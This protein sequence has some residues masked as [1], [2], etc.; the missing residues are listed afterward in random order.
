MREKQS[1]VIL[2]S[3]SLKTGTY[4]IQRINGAHITM[5]RYVEK[6]LEPWVE[7]CREE[8]DLSPTQRALTILDVYKAHQTSDVIDVL[9]EAGFELVFVP[10]N[11]TSE[12]EPLQL[13]VN[14]CFKVELKERFTVWYAE[15][16]QSAMRLHPDDV[17]VAIKSVQPD[18]RLSV[19]KPLHARW[20]TEAFGTLQQ[21]RDIVENGWHQ[22]GITSAF[23]SAIVSD[24]SPPA[25]KLPLSPA[26]TSAIHTVTVGPSREL[27][28]FL[29][30][31]MRHV[32]G[33][34]F[35]DLFPV[36][37]EPVSH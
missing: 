21:K 33:L 14:S 15:C 22:P 23:G 36:R 20:I 13:A 35:N 16:V 6:V 27:S 4:G 11:C 37:I 3:H 30:S 25:I 5:K 24:V 29:A 31:E 7:H 9:K 34:A 2:P 12:L 10:G 1:G 26:K 17:Q 32:D 18:L 28:T 8:L 19:M